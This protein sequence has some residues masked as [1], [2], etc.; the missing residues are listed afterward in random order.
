M[1]EVIKRGEDVVD[2]E[3]REKSR[4]E[5]TDQRKNKLERDRGTQ[6]HNEED[7][8]KKTREVG[9]GRKDSREI[10]AEEVERERER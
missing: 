4:K 5:G 2:E 8:Q 3:K 9:N 6:D 10:T 7:K 1:V